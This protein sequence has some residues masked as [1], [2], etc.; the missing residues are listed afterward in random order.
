MGGGQKSAIIKASRHSL[1]T[2]SRASFGY[3]VAENR[4]KIS[5]LQINRHVGGGFWLAG[6]RGKLPGKSCK[7]QHLLLKGSKHR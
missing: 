6:H 4:I 2:V 5:R 1:Q 7:L 3:N